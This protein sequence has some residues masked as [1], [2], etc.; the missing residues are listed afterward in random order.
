MTI[1]QTFQ[2]AIQHHQSGRAA[3]AE[4][5]YRQ[6]LAI[7]PDNADA[8]HMLGLLAHQLGHHDAGAELIVQAVAIAPEN[9][10]FHSNLATV[11]FESGRLDEAIAAYR[12]TIE[13]E[14]GYAGAHNSLGH[15]LTLKGELDEA[16][17]ACNR[18]IALQPDYAMAHNN[19]GNALGKIGR[20]DE[21]IASFL[22]AT[23]FKPDYAEAY[24]NLA[25][26]LS[27]KGRHAEAIAA[28]QR[29]IEAKP[30]FANAHNVLGDALMDVQRVDEAV[31][32]YRQ[33]S[34]IDDC[35]EIQNNLGI[36][37]CELGKLKESAAAYH[38]A[39]K[40]QPDHAPAH[41]NLGNTLN[42]QGRT[43]DALAA[44]R[45][46][47]ELQP[48]YA[49]ARNNLGNLLM[50]LGRLEEAADACE[51]A[52]VID[53]D[54]ATAKWNRS[55]LHLLRGEFE[56]GWPLHEARWQ[57][58]G[59]SSPK[60]N[61]PQ[62]MW[63]GSPLNGR[64]L[65]VHAE[66]G[67]GDSIQFVRYV[68]LVAAR[69]GAVVVECPRSLAELFGTVAG[70]SEVIPEGAPL[71][72]FDLHVP[73]L[74]LPFV[75]GTTLETVPRELPYLTP[76]PSRCLAWR[77]LL[78]GGARLKVGLAW[79]GN[80]G[81]LRDRLRSIPLRQLL[82]VLGVDGVDFISLQKD[83]GSAQP[84]QFAAATK[85]ADHTAHIH[86]FA[87]TAA[88]V[89]Q[90]DLVIA[91]DTSVAHLAGALGKPV[92]VLL[93]FAP[94]WRWMVEREDSPWYPTMRLFRQQRIGDWDPVIA[95]VRGELQ[96]FAG[97]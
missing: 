51:Q 85:M 87:D 66:Q 83:V 61:F 79:A 44:Y 5:A 78:G 97:S 68:P 21:A 57:T 2:L 32:A 20:L 34:R 40:L 46:A 84:R 15:A 67:F 29:A 90:L 14:P 88:L 41:S 28:C 94:D 49:V 42:Q 7:Q 73:M 6:V 26:A 70:V 55:L 35:A 91:V 45:R 82:P 93:P 43:E 37:L 92:W 27:D 48:D 65:L 58:K 25:I 13:L 8:L 30:N 12:R 47:I 75:L 89:S 11:L 17:A 64:R 72:P 3:E 50:H 16:V 86:S 62:P 95:K 31:A 23:H 36:A 81:H 10:V 24:V 53:P 96:A 19:L 56:K 4:A 71:P 60:R 77:E 39:I 74:S 63:D 54:F 76:F 33:A 52:L 1:Q 18:A 22:R 59:F 38:R 9:S 80:P 69:G